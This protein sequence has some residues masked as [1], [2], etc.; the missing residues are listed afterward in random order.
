MS[1]PTTSLPKKKLVLEESVFD[2]LYEI[3]EGYT[4]YIQAILNRLYGYGES[5]TKTEQVVATIDRLIAEYEYAYQHL[6]Q[7]YTPTAVHLL[8]AIAKEQRVIEINAGSFIKK[9]NLKAASSVNTALS[10]LL[11]NEVVYK[12]ENGYI[13]YDRLMS[14]WLGRQ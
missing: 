3:F 11:K 6:L 12:S 14:K 9:Y 10:K 5:V 8:K 1:L 13:I 4:W 7:A 2:E